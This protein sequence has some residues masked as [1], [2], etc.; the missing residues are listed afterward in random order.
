MNVQSPSQAVF[1]SF[2]FLLGCYD[3]SSLRPEEEQSQPKSI[4]MNGYSLLL[5]EG[6]GWIRFKSDRDLLQMGRRG[7]HTDETVMFDAKVVELP[8][9]GS[10]QEFLQSVKESTARDCP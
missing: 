2:L 1:L 4:S 6:P 7:D 3:N 9:F 8:S 10:D 5:P